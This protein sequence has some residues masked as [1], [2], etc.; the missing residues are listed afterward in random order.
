MS[1]TFKLKQAKHE[2]RDERL[3]EIKSVNFHQ[4][5]IIQTQIS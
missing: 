1:I 2:K 5:H 3:S 4:R